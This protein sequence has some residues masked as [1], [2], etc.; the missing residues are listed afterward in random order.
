MVEFVECETLHRRKLAMSASTNS[1]HH[2]SKSLVLLNFGSGFLPWGLSNA[3][4]AHV[5]VSYMAGIRNFS[6]ELQL[7]TAVFG[8]HYCLA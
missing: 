4:P 7:A 8:V 2:L 6:Y 3:G 1:G 5:A